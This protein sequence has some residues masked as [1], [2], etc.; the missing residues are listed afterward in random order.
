MSALKVRDL[1]ST[2]KRAMTAPDSIQTTKAI[3]ALIDEAIGWLGTLDRDLVATFLT[4]RGV[5]FAVV[6]RVLSGPEKRR[7]SSRY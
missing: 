2:G 1:H 4:R 3:T 5:H 6:V 7:A